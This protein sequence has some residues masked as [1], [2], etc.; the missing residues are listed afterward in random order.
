MQHLDKFNIRDFDYPIK[1]YKAIRQAEYI[2]KISEQHDL[3]FPVTFYENENFLKLN[4]DKEELF[5]A[6]THPHKESTN[7]IL[8]YYEK[9]FVN[10]VRQNCN[11]IFLK[12][13]D[14]EHNNK[15]INL[16]TEDPVDWFLDNNIVPETIMNGY[17]IQYS[18]NRFLINLA[19]KEA[20]SLIFNNQFDHVQMLLPVYKDFLIKKYY[21]HQKSKSNIEIQILK[22]AEIK[23]TIHLLSSSINI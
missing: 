19:F 4:I 2:E 10:L 12:I 6:F 15:N 11:V 13:D 23:N 16:A 3:I 22:E 17:L 5:N 8:D 21:T 20:C 7:I 9:A 1:S 14:C 18:I